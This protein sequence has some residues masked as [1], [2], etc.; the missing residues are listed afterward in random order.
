MKEYYTKQ[1]NKILETINQK[2]LGKELEEQLLSYLHILT[3]NYPED[4]QHRASIMVEHYLSIVKDFPDRIK[5]E[6][7][8]RGPR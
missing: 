6:G 1:V 3:E 8:G 5:E 4:Q 7:Q 2:D